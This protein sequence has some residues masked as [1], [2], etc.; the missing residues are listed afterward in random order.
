MKCGIDQLTDV[1]AQELEDYSQ[2]ITDGIKKEVKEVAKE[3]RDE[4]KRNSP[5]LTGSYKKGWRTKT[6]YEG[7][8]DIRVTV[9]NKT[10]YQLTHLLEDGHLKKGGTDRVE[11][12]PHIAPA[13]Q[14]AARKLENHVKVLIR[15]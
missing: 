7:R 13:E 4:I 9:H 8:E 15:K 10:D 6:N 11:G 5:V 2:E 1:I 12:R 14:N 3:C